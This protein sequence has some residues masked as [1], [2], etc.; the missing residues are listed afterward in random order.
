MHILD[1]DAVDLILL[2]VYIANILVIP[3]GLPFTFY[4]MDLLLEYQNGKFMLFRSDC[5]LIL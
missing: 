2:Q 3:R 4:K 5:G 1:T